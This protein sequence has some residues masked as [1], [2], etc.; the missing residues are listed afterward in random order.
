MS[1]DPDTEKKMQTT[2]SRPHQLATAE[3]VAQR[4]GVKLH[5]VYELIRTD[6]L[7]HVRLGRTVRVDPAKLEAWIESGGTGY[8]S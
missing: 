3:W 6:K 4:L 7:P 2:L 1:A 5:R 8:E